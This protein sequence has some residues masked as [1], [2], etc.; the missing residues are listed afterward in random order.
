MAS[1]DSRSE[2]AQLEAAETLQ[3]SES[4]WSAEGGISA[5]KQALNP[6]FDSFGC[7]LSHCTHRDRHEASDMSSHNLW[8]LATPF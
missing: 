6:T 2:E 4:V 7:V 1:L 5:F 8:M 3:T